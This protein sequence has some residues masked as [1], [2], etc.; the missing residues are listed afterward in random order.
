MDETIKLK[1]KISYGL[2]DLGS[3]L[4]YTTTVLWLMFFYTNVFG[5]SPAIAGTLLLLARIWDAVNDP[6]MGIII[7]KT[8]TKWGKT[9]PYIFAFAVPVSIVLVLTFYTPTL[10]DSSK[11]IYACLT[12]I[13]LVTFYTAVNLPYGAM[14]PLITLDVE[15]RTSFSMFRKLGSSFG[16]II[17]SFVPVLVGLLGSGNTELEINRSGYFRVMIIFG[18]ITTILYFI[19]FIN[20][21]ERIEIKNEDRLTVKEAFESIKVNRPWLIITLFTF[22][23]FTIDAIIAA[24]LM[25]YI[26]YFLNKS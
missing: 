22:V 5:L 3:N 7:D 16:M 13:I 4:I 19:T 1:E 17:V 18:I 24:S 6:L 21:K 10:S 11:I 20:T 23:V 25:Y 26:K 2:G 9:R 15:E 14:L 12:Y 8:S